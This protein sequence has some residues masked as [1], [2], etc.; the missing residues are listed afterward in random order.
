M[1]RIQKFK[2]N[3]IT[4]IFNR[5]A[6]VASGLILPRLILNY[7]GSEV[8]GLA[9]S[10]TQF[11]SI[12][13]FLDLGV[14]SVVQTALY[15]PLA[16]KDNQQVSQVLTSAKTYFRHISYALIIY[17]LLLVIFY[18]II[19][20]HSWDHL[21]TSFL[22]IS[23]SLGIFGQYYFGI[24][25]Q[26]LLSA[27]Q[28]AYLQL[29]TE[30]LVVVLNLV[31][32]I[33]LIMNNL[34]FI[35]VKF[36]S[37]LV[38]LIRP[39]L[40]TMYVKRNYDISTDIELDEEPLDQKW[41]G[42]A[43]HLAHTV[44]NN[45]SVVMLTFFSTLKNISVYSIYHMVV[46]GVSQLITSIVYNFEAFFG[47]LLAEDETDSLKS[48]FAKIEWSVH[49]IVVYLYGLTAALILSFVEIYTSGVDD[50]NYYTPA[51]ALLLILSQ[52]TFC[53]RLPYQQ[54]VFAAG[55]YKQ[56]QL[57]SIIE[58][59]INLALSLSLVHNFHLVGV[60]VATLAAMLYRTFYL[61]NY[62]SKNIIYRKISF[63]VKQFLVDMLT[64]GMMLSLS[65]IFSYSP[66]SFI[67]WIIYA[68]FMGV[69]YLI[70]V[71]GINMI[72][73]N[74]QMKKILKRADD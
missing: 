52:M 8:N 4:S 27:D 50:A 74:K 36:F 51:F 32:S 54:L 42:V 58:A 29:S 68:I 12:I 31:V 19:V 6:V 70:L 22:I 67:Y 62:L 2:L 49:T 20:S 17:V 41:N 66:E 18:P 24:V 45:T 69:I 37:S 3:T 65:Y 64:L 38:Y 28:K 71:A 72:F 47:N 11:L 61:V 57:S 39:V 15:R 25:N 9:Q 33:V 1:N 63:F 34:S 48:Y 13:T 14:G 43:Q 59:L 46:V 16:Q 5:I 23:M 73:Y 10:I 30:I 35:T 53:I 44:N 55:H 60:A 21:A 40:L 7:Y 26:L 56:T